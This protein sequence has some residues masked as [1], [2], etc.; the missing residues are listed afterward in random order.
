[1]RRRRFIGLAL[2]AG[3]TVGNR[4]AAAHHA[5]TAIDNGESLTLAGVVD[6]MHWEN[7]HASLLG[8]PSVRG[9]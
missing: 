1:M 8:A 9:A 2:V 6:E 4:A 5:W 3:A 7:P